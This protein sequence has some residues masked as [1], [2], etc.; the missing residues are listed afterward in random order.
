MVSSDVNEGVKEKR[1]FLRNLVNNMKK[2][3]SM[4]IE[5]K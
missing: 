5:A 1:A 4:Y 3:Y 2:L